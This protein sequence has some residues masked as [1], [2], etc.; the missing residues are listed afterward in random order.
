MLN[1]KEQKQLTSGLVAQVGC[2]VNVND[3]LDAFG[4]GLRAAVAALAQHVSID[5]KDKGQLH[6]DS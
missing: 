2:P 6:D 5:P 3:R 1:E 4:M